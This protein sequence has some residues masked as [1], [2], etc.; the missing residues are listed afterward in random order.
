M[1][2]LKKHHHVELKKAQEKQEK[3]REN[4]AKKVKTVNTYLMPK[5]AKVDSMSASCYSLDSPSTSFSSTASTIPLCDSDTFARDANFF[6]QQSYEDSVSIKWKNDDIRSKEIDFK[7][8]EMIAMD[9]QPYSLVE[10]KGFQ[11]L[12]YSLKPKYDF[13]SRSHFT[14]VII[15]KIYASAVKSIKNMINE[16]SFMSLTTDFWSVSAGGDQ[17]LSLTGHCVFKDFKQQAIV[18]NIKP[19]KERHTAPNITSMI[20]TMVEFYIP[21]HKIHS[22]VHDN[23]ANMTLG[24]EATKYDSLSCF[25]HTSQLALQECIFNQRVVNDIIAKCKNLHS[26]FSK[27]YLAT[28]RLGQIQ[29]DLGHTQLVLLNDSA[30]RWDSTYLMVERAIKLKEDLLLYLSRYESECDVNFH[31]YEWGLMEKISSLLQIFYLMTKHMSERYANSGDIIPH[32]MIAKDYVTD[33]LTRSRLTGL[34]TTLTSLK[35]S[36]D[37]RFSKYLNDMNCIIATYL[38]P[39]HKDLFDNEDYGSI[40]STANIELALIEKYL[41]YAKEKDNRE[42]ETEVADQAAANEDDPDD[43]PEVEADNDFG[44]FKHKKV[45]VLEWY[46]AR[47][48]ADKANPAAFLKEIVRNHHQH[49]RPTT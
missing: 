37:T 29:K 35:E 11:R 32:V 33:E 4:R 2:H 48:Y 49:L 34:N 24:I 39:R 36:F 45:D 16:V 10:D 31:S 5:K 13:K 3:E 21:P 27:S 20:E 23:A 1:R 12:I 40:R 44:G 8:G 22:I 38:D 42:K 43:A 14:R 19:F 7:I 18:L 47:L 15:P 26:H 6:K 17:F 30:T 41:K 46:H 9:N 28:D 25:I